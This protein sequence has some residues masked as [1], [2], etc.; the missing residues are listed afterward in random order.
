MNENMV[1]RLSTKTAE[2][3]F[4]YKLEQEFEYAP[5]VAEAILKEAQSCL[6]SQKETMKPG[7]IRVFLTK[8][9]ARHGRPLRE[10]E[11]V[12]VLWTIDA[13][14]TDL[15]LMQKEGVAGLRRARIR[16]LLDEALKQGAAA[17]QE[18]LAWALNVSTRTIRR[19]SAELRAE[20]Q[21]VRT[22]GKLQGIG[23]G[24]THKRQIVAHWL[25]G[26]TYDQIALQ[27]R[28]NSASIKRYIQGFLRVTHLTNEG[29]S[30]EEIALLLSM[31]R[32][33][34]SEYLQLHGENESEMA[35]RRLKNH[36]LSIAG[37]VPTA[38]RGVK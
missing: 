10:T 11:K 17:T 35:K 18:D 6:L 13:G 26:E 14:S 9:G 19:D 33:L 28:H 7:Q 23:R 32:S 20:G 30:L 3:Q 8:R 34:V 12:E 36:R 5:R 1:E 15:M 16:R 4:L 27:C 22:R 38:K 2:Q 29:L 21:E 25:A 31:S 24:Q 37:G